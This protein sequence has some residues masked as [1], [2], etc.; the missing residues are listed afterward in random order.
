MI[1]RELPDINLGGDTE[2]CEGNPLV[3]SAPVAAAWEWST[4]ANSQNV[5]VTETGEYA[6]TI[7]DFY[8]CQNSDDVYV[9]I[10]DNPVIDLGDNISI[11]E[12]EMIVIELDGIFDEYAWSTGE[13][14]NSIEVYGEVLGLGTHTISVTVT[15]FNTCTGSDQITITVTPTVEVLNGYVN[16]YTVYPNPTSGIINITGDN[17]ISCVIF[18]NI[19]QIILETNNSEIDMSNYEN[20]IYYVKILTDND[21]KTIKFV[22]H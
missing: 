5:N 16:T 11:Q 14:T 20:G 2:I 10:W 1:I 12:H 8:G 22:K 7:T 6:C 19:G 18:N 21:T 13:T 17:I 3:L 15:D 9:T 4:G